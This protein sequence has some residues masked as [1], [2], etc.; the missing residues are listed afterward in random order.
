MSTGDLLR[1]EVAKKTEL[2]N[3]C[4][5]LMK[6]GKMVPLEITLNLLVNAMKDNSDARGFLIDGF[7]RTLE[8]AI[9]VCIVSDSSLKRQW[10]KRNS[11]CSLTLAKNV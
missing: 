2:G 6:E 1:E 11:S 9:E 5:E 3:Q 10:E 8:Q 4:D 7:P